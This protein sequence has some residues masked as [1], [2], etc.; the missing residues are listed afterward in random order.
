MIVQGVKNSSKITK[1][2]L[3]SRK[4]ALDKALE[5][6]EVIK[7]LSPDHKKALAQVLQSQLSQLLS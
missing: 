3:H 7:K 6:D 4:E 2:E 1:N 5:Q